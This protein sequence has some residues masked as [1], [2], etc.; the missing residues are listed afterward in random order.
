VD[1]S[2]G[3]EIQWGSYSLSGGSGSW[4]LALHELAGLLS[5]WLSGKI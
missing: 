2:T 5:Y 3:K 4:Q 1:Y